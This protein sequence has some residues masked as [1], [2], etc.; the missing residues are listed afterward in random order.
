MTDIQV[1][2]LIVGGGGAG[3]TASM[4]LSQLG[5]ESLLVSALPTTSILP[6]AHVLNQRSMEIFRGLGIAERI[7]ERGTPPAQMQ[8]TAW[9]AGLAG[10][11]P[12]AGRRIARLEA[13]GAGGRDLAW[14]AASACR[15]TNLPQ[16]RLEPILKARAEE[17]APGR[18]RFAHEL[19][20][21]EQDAEGVT[22]DRAGSRRRRAVSR[23][24]PLSARVRRRPQRRS[25][26]R[27]HAR[28]PAQPRERGLRPHDGRPVALVAGPGRADPL[29]LAARDAACSPCWCRWAP[30]AGA[31]TRRSGSST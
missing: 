14:A 9:Y 13:W 7:Y 26:A 16:V 5:V 22:R 30:S 6:K 27:R 25:Q 21:L 31:R 11:H 23:A 2:V 1:P 17:L 29:A 20:E 24:R 10:S 15:S 12:N 4:L 19:V 18:V 28:R 3:L 8:A